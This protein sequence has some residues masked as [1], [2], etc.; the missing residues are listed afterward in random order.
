[1]T[2]LEIEELRAY[3]KEL[4]LLNDKERPQR[5]KKAKED[6]FFMAKTYFAHHIEYAKKEYSRFRKFIHKDLEKL[7]QRY[8][9]VVLTAYRGAAKTTTVSNLFVLQQ[10][11]KKSRRFIVIISSTDTLAKAIFEVIKTELEDNKR[12]VSDF[13]IEIIKSNDSEI[14]LKIDDHLMK[15]FCAGSGA[16]IRGIRFLS[17][18]P[19]LIILDDIENDENVESKTQRDK[20]FRWYSKTIKKLPSRR[21]KSNIIIVGTILHHDSLLARLRNSNEVFYK[22]F[23]LVLDFKKFTLDDTSLNKEQF[24]LEYKED[25]ESFLQEYQN[26]PISSDAL[27]FNGYKTYEIMPKCDSFF[28]G[29]D[30]AMGKAKGDYFAIAILGYSKEQQKFY[31]TAKG[32]KKNPTDMIDTLLKLYIRYSKKARTVIA[33]ETVAYQEF[34]KDVFKKHAKALGIVPTVFSLKNSVPKEIRINS[35]APLIK[36]GD[37]LVDKNATLLI[38]ELDTYP[39]SP[40]DDLLDASEM[41]KRVFETG[42]GIDYK[43]VAKMQKELKKQKW[44]KIG[45]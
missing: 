9:I 10:I 30:P 16:K 29:V 45:F 41:A 31:L 27:L 39:K 34:F 2:K 44:L 3:L 40:H 11:I 13:N 15:L 42:G 6:L 25:K 28:I 5:V 38:E 14:V 26:I 33:M 1:M 37:I 43:K 12:F 36:D 7:L 21:G 19:D 18:R 4:P 24:K 32:Y 22:N 23:P 17:Y 8:S 35:L 20:L